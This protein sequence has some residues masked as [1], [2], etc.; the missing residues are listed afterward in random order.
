MRY[1]K[2][3]S[4]DLRPLFH[5]LLISAASTAFPHWTRHL[6]RGSMS[7]MGGLKDV[8]CE[9]SYDCRRTI[10]GSI[11]QSVISID[12]QCCNQQYSRSDMDLPLFRVC[13]GMT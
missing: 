2:W 8:I 11:T 4:A 10:S 1:A 5:E 9:A 12:N 3:H 13:K 6:I 7:D